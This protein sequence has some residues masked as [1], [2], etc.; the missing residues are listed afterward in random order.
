MSYRPEPIDASAVALSAD[1]R[2]LTEVL[3]DADTALTTAIDEGNDAQGRALVQELGIEAL[4][5]NADWVLLH[6]DRPVTVPGTKWRP[7]TTP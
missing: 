4:A 3:A 5:E 1:L 2:E 6:R 7:A